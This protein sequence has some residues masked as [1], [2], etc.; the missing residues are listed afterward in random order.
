MMAELV[1]DTGALLAWERNG[2]RIRALVQLATAGEVTLRTSSAVVAQAWR[3]GSRQA[4]LAK[5]LASG[6]LD[7]RPLDPPAGR[8]VGVLAARTGASDVVG[9]HVASLALGRPARVVTSDPDDLSRW[10]VD[11]QAILRC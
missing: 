10:G 4:R 11:P 1:L 2:E 7:E 8:R 6:T 3:G 5:L 9:G